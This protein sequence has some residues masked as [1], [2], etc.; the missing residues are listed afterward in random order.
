VLDGDITASG[1]ISSLVTGDGYSAILMT[2]HTA[3]ISTNDYFNLNTTTFVQV[4][5]DVKS[6]SGGG[7]HFLYIKNDNTL[8]GI[9]DNEDGQ[10][11]NGI[12][13]WQDW[14]DPYQI[15][16]DVA[17]CAAMGYHTGYIKTNGTLWMT[18]ANWS[19][20]LGLGD[21]DDRYSP[22]QVDTD[23][24]FVGGGDSFTYYIKND[25]TL[26]AM[27]YNNNGQ[28]GDG[29]YNNS[30]VPI[31]IDTNVSYAVGGNEHGL[32]IKNNNTLYGMGYNYY[33]QLTK[34]ALPYA[35][36]YTNATGWTT[37]GVTGFTYND[38][39]TDTVYWTD[40]LY[41]NGKFI[42]GGGEGMTQTIYSS[43]GKTW[44]TGSITNVDAGITGIAYNGTDTYVAVS[45]VSNF[46]SDGRPEVFTSSDGI[47]WITGS[48]NN[49]G[50]LGLY[51]VTY[52]GGKFVAGGEGRIVTST[53]GDS[54][55]ERTPPFYGLNSRVAYGAGKYVVTVGLGSYNDYSQKNL[56]TQ[57]FDN[58]TA[59]FVSTGHNHAMLLE[60]GTLYGCGANDRG[61]IGLNGH[62]N[63]FV[64]FQPITSNVRNVLCGYE[65][66]T[67]V[68]NDS[69]LWGMG[70]ND[71]AQLD[72]TFI[73]RYSP[74]QID[75]N[76]SQS[77]GGPRAENNV[78]Y[79]KNDNTLWGRGH[80][81]YGQLGTASLDG[82]V[83]QSVQLDTNVVHASAGS[84]HI[85]YVKSDGTLYGMGYNG[86]GQLGTGDTAQ[87]TSSYQ[88][89]TNVV[90]CAVGDYSSYYIKNDGTLYAMGYNNSGQLGLGDTATKYTASLVTG[91]VATISATYDNAEFVSTDGNVYG[92]G[93]NGDGEFGVG[94]YTTDALEPRFVR[95]GGIG[96]KVSC[97]DYFTY[98]I[99]SDGTVYSTGIDEY[100]RLGLYNLVDKGIYSSDGETWYSSSLPNYWYNDVA[101]GNGRFV[102]VAQGDGVAV[103]STDGMN[104][105]S[106]Y[107]NTSSYIVSS[108]V[109]FDG[110][111]FVSTAYFSENGYNI[112]TSTDG[113][114]WTTTKTEANQIWG[115]IAYGD[116]KYTLLS[117]THADTV[118]PKTELTIG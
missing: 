67:F 10:L 24:K 9:G 52:G 45:E 103:S 116:G 72:Y 69:T 18:G 25:G 35:M 4:A 62:I 33:W 20:Q 70:Y 102:M 16:A 8:W 5:S 22:L 111:K 27:G 94:D 106:S 105:T 21:S 91:S 98:L 43:D 30:Y 113:V 38:Q 83:T 68:K 60:N 85:L 117:R 36:Y 66:T 109:I 61:Q 50:W 97:G 32:Y 51:G 55:T 6:I 13:P 59:S 46:Y 7:Y 39:I 17:S 108:A 47:N 34:D 63:K 12:N 74:V 76:V 80:N 53:D 84:K 90:F 75:S 82:Y 64:Y 77:F 112:A 14:N 79:I 114:L 88:I 65:H 71:N 100:G 95:I 3:W 42:A 28:I 31:V 86:Q 15:D 99:E 11:G 81:D 118:L 48:L 73:E 87:Q 93:Y 107:M 58:R 78:F 96:A 44:N 57:T 49:T 41:A 56:F 19:G 26:Y 89:D 40:S 2:D 54:W 104:W 110:T 1:D 37:E 23:I 29:S 101:Y 115:T 92:M